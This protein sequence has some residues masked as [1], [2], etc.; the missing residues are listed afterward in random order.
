M[1]DS[2]ATVW[3]GTQDSLGYITTHNE[4]LDAGRP[5]LIVVEA[6]MASEVAD[7]I[8]ANAVPVLNV[9][10]NRESKNPGISERVE[11]FL[12]AVFTRLAAVKE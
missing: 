2:N 7:W 11:R 3:F 10:G 6:M 8:E 1:L 12:A 9:A 4:A 5:F